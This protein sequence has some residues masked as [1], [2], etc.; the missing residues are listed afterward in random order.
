[1][2]TAL[3]S[4]LIARGAI[5]PSTKSQVANRPKPVVLKLDE[6]GKAAA[7]RHIAEYHKSPWLF[8]SRPQLFDL[9]AW[10]FP[11]PQEDE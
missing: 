8:H 2:T 10:M 1:M 7:A 5:R 9:D 3:R 4:Q 6:A 11:E